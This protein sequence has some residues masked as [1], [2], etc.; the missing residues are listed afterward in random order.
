[1]ALTRRDFLKTTAVA[2]GA[3]L[4]GDLAAA[5]PPER[6][7]YNIIFV[8]NDQWRAHALGYRKQDPVVTPCLDAFANEAVCFNNGI[9]SSP[10]CGPN[11][12]CWLT[13][14]Y[15]L[16][17]GLLRNAGKAIEPEQMLTRHFKANGYK[18]GYVGKWHMGGSAYHRNDIAPERYRTHYDYWY[19]SMT[20]EHFKLWF[21]DHGKEIDEGGGWQPDHE[22]DKAIAFIKQ[23]DDRPFN[24]VLSFGPPHNGPFTEG[25]CAEKRWT[26]GHHSNKKNGYGY[27]GPQ[28]HEVHYLNLKPSDIRG[29]VQDVPVKDGDVESETIAGAIAGYYGACTAIDAAFGRL[30]T[31]LKDNGLYDNT[32]V[33]F[34][35][36]HGEMMGSHGF[37]TKGV[38]FEESI[39]VP[40]M[41]HVPRVA[42]RQDETLFNSVDLMPTLMGLTG[43]AVPDG[44]DGI[45]LS[46]RVR[47]PARG[48]EP[49]M[50]YIGYANW[51]GWRTR[52]YTY[53]ATAMGDKLGGREAAYLRNGGHKPSSHI[54]FDLQEDPL[55][56]RPIFKGTGA[57][58]DSLIDDFHAQLMTTVG[59]M[60]E[61]IPALS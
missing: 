46:E 58:T 17:H 31:Y 16:N 8:Q 32:I 51:R 19:R 10:V 33:V 59:A 6:R 57:A 60:G 54:L 44:L 15:H 25:Y 39:N 5:D 35:S 13:G 42:A 20:H 43:Q 12:A 30:I 26:P 38:S 48:P 7:P 56:Q 49:E 11:R 29:N 1:M 40:L 55:Q 50:A 28:D 23:R 45:D 41:V 21:D 36:D 14:L 61:T 27:Y 18:N 22:T 53:V 34:T 47:D 2:T 9:A 37:M 52:R 24:L 3:M 4:L